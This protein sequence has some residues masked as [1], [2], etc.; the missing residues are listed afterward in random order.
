MRY[1]PSKTEV[2]KK[3]NIQWLNS[4]KFPD[5]SFSSFGI[6]REVLVSFENA[7]TCTVIYPW[8]K[9]YN[10]ARRE[11][12]NVYPASPRMIIFV[13]YIQDIQESLKFAQTYKLETRIRSG[14]HSM[15]DYSIC[16]GIVIDIS[17]L[18]SV[19]INTENQT[20]YVEAGNRFEDLNPRLEAVGMH[21]P[22]GGCP[23]VSVA[24]YM[25]GGGYG[26]TSR[27]FGIHSDNVLEVLIVLAN[28]TLMVASPEKNA[29]LFWA[30]RGGTGGNFGVLVSITYKIF[31]LDLMWGLQ[32]TWDFETDTS[33]AALALYTIQER[34]LVGFQ[35]PN[36]GIETFVYTDIGGDN[37]VKVMFGAGFIGSEE[38]LDTAIAPLMAVPGATVMY[39]KKAKYSVINNDVLEG[40]PAIPIDQLP[41]VKYYGRSTYISRSLSVADY[42]N[43]LSFFRTIPNTFG[44]F[45]M[46]GYG[47]VI[48]T[49]PVEKSAFI[50]R[51]ATMDFF[52]FLF[53]DKET[54]D[55]EKNRLWLISLFEFMEQYSNGHSYQNYPNRDQEGFQW[56][57]WGQYYNQL[58]AIKNKYDPNNFFNY[59]QSIGQPI[60]T[61]KADQQ[62]LLF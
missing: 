47:G 22:G 7:L 49:F 35:Y 57:Y 44:M 51:K 8:S 29:D 11:F 53:F 16:D 45:G 32:I 3:E 28:G 46:E 37:H 6:T 56:A 18:K 40:I 61:D 52:C 41:D 26:L 13:N 1:K 62:I 14:R 58:V 39:K 54:N 38:E 20:A 15:T 31:P 19:Y 55:Q 21:L 2:Q 24:G 60:S 50:H 12:N 36:L 43:I 23:S 25:Q 34:Y 17:N 42:K 30:I 48:N 27:N 9:G 33:N 5:E 59:Q 4:D 10:K